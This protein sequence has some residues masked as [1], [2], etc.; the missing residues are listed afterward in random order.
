METGLS[1][2]DQTINNSIKH[3]SYTLSIQINLNGLSFCIANSEHKVIALETIIFGTQLNPEQVLDKI[4]YLFKSNVFLQ[5]NI[6]KV[7]VVYNNDLYTLVPK[8]LFDEKLLSDYLKFNIKVLDNDYIAYDVINSHDVVNVY[9]PYVNINNFFFE[10]F[11]TFTYKHATT[12][13]TENLLIA[14]K[15]SITDSV[16]AHITHNSFDLII[17]KQGKLQLCNTYYIETAED[18]LYYVMFAAEQL[19]LNPETFSLIFIGAIDKQH[20]YYK[21][22]YTYIRNIS[23]GTRNNHF[24]I[25]ETLKNIS[26]Y[27]DFTLLS[28]F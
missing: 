1:L 22:A 24:E 19:K 5:R 18:F 3:I 15:N 2:M 28:N 4:K 10:N 25:A 27:Q 9:V 20:P 17:I 26:D 14:E 12:V 16:Y 7:N 11:G 8:A 13:L 6:T 23:F 21:I